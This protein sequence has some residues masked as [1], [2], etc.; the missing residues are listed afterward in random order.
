M[1][2]ERASIQRMTGYVPGKQPTTADTIKLNTNEN[3]Y[4]PAP[5]VMR[6]LLEVPADVLRR[7]P[8]PLADAFREIAAEVHGV[9]REQIVAVNGGD[10]LL[11]L[12]VTTFVEPGT[13][14]GVLEPSYSLYPVLAEI[15][16]SPL[17]RVPAGSGSPALRGGSTEDFSVPADFA[18]R[19]NS[20]RV[21]LAM[22]VNPHAPSGTL[23]SRSQISAIA[24]ELRGVLLV[25][26]AYVD[27]AD[28]ELGHD[29][30]PLL[31][32][33]DNLL[34]LRTLSKG[35]SLAGLRFG[36]G[37]GRAEL[38]APMLEKTRDSYNV[39]VVAQR[40]AAAALHSRGYAVETWKSVRQERARLVDA[41][42]ALG[43]RVLPSQ[44]NFLLAYVPAGASASQLRDRL[45]AGGLLV[46]HFAQDRLHDALRITVGTPE[47]NDR[48]LEL[49][50][51]LLGR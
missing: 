13:P 3:P 45:E 50:S 49:L 1:A 22:L 30:L 31:A 32:E 39:D 25:D 28:P 43:L 15:H 17:V 38:I 5:E 48:L 8:E 47:Q 42:A 21:N 40:L 41:L 6:A 44:S 29:L 2:Y 18:A 34:F 51:G 7:Y 37:I 46:R 19:L 16:G 10:E 33:H 14:I 9:A 12:A 27:F 36:Y 4:P 35:Y 11:R 23:V 26:E 24:R 20:E